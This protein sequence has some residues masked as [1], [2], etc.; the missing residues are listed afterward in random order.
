[1]NKYRFSLN[2]K[3]KQ[4]NKKQNK[5]QQTNKQRNKKQLKQKKTKQKRPFIEMVASLIPRTT[6][7]RKRERVKQFTGGPSDWT[8][9]H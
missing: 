2:K 3:T 5:N 1:M 7:R 6:W 8:L 9:D 4:E